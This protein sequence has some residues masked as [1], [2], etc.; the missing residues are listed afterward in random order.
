MTKN[1][2]KQSSIST[3]EVK[4]MNTLWA[5]GKPLFES[6][7]CE[8]LPKLKNNKIQKLLEKLLKRQFI[9][10]VETVEEGSVLKRS[11]STVITPE[12]YTAKYVNFRACKF[13]WCVL[14]YL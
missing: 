7:I 12:E 8:R 14:K 1:K 9:E 11:Y 10:V 2:K 6:E 4:V 3:R 5:E 13:S